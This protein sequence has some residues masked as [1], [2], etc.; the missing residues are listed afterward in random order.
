MALMTKSPRHSLIQRGF[1][2]RKEAQEPQSCLWERTRAF[3]LLV[4]LELFG[5]YTFVPS[6]DLLAVKTY[7]N[8]YQ[9]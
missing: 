1:Y 4:I 3:F 8:A 9:M 6:P 7:A 5:G 2:G